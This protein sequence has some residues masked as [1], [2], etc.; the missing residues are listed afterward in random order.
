MTEQEA[1]AVAVAK[2]VSQIYYEKSFIWVLDSTSNFIS[3]TMYQKLT[4][5]AI[6]T[7]DPMVLKANPFDTDGI[8][9][10]M[11]RSCISF[12]EMMN[13]A[14]T[15]IPGIPL[16][17]GIDTEAAMYPYTVDV[18]EVEERQA[19]NLYLHIIRKN[20]QGLILEE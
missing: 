4:F 17:E 10:K 8:L 2:F 20:A 9:K 18:E 6:P 15:D 5:I 1:K 11:K 13:N 3:E 19:E 12:K 16:E 7:E 14:N